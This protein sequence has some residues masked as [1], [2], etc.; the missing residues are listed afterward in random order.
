M[1]DYCSFYHSSLRKTNY[2]QR[3]LQLKTWASVVG[4][5]NSNFSLE[6]ALFSVLVLRERIFCAQL[7]LIPLGPE[8]Y[9]F[10]LLIPVTPG[11]K[12]QFWYIVLELVP[13]A[14]LLDHQ[15]C[16]PVKSDW[17]VHSQ[18]LFMVV[19]PQYIYD[20]YVSTNK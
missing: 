18:T 12:G 11:G 10:D 1:S 6:H 16:C 13:S 2:L 15:K 19:L 14:I 7:Y 5:Q 9:N 8:K 17:L 3:F 20:I 4:D